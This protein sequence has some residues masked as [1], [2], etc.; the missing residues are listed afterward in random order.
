MI[1]IIPLIEDE[2]GICVIGKNDMYKYYNIDIHLK[3]MII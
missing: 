1:S 3:H 2:I